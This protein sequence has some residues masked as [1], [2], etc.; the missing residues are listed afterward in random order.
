MANKY[1]D[2]NGLL[3]FWQKIKARFVEAITYDTNNHK[4]VQSKNGSTSDIVSADTLKADMG[5]SDAYIMPST[6]IPASDM[7][8]SVQ[9]SLGLADTALQKKS[10]AGIVYSAANS[11]AT[12]AATAAQIVSAIGDTSVA[13]ATSDANGNAITST[14]APIASP[15]LT[16]SPTAP[17]ASAGTST[18]QIATTA[19]VSEAV[20]AAQMGAA[21]F[22]GVVN[23]SSDISS[24]AYKQGWYWVV[25]TAGTY[26][27]QQ[28]EAG[29][30]IFAIADKSSSYSSSDFSIV[31][32]NLDITSITNAEIDAIVAA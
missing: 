32:T 15:A 26:V 28:C 27:G 9:A 21:T 11:T 24:S 23:S 17:T 31:Q 16:G 12:S 10:A 13:R 7:S 20:A 29:D 6:G 8:S 25:G 3:Y 14:Y 18:T 30:M 4:I 22:K 1:L 2:D 5:L 19:F